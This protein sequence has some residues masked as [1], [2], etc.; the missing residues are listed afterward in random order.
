MLAQL[1]SPH[2][3]LSVNLSFHAVDTTKEHQDIS[4]FTFGCHIYWTGGSTYI[5]CMRLSGL[6]WQYIYPYVVALRMKLGHS[7]GFQH[8]SSETLSQTGRP[9]SWLTLN[10]GI[11]CKQHNFNA[12]VKLSITQQVTLN[13]VF[14]YYLFCRMHSTVNVLYLQTT[15][16]GSHKFSCLISIMEKMICM[17]YF[18]LHFAQL[19]SYNLL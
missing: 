1:R 6:N 2:V 4:S 11:D 12:A 19:V 13:Q 7:S 18:L 10:V 14:G 15:I 3:R 17:Q 5:F 8:A 16:K 9:L